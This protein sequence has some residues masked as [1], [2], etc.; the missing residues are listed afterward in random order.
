M[1][2]WVEPEGGRERG[3]LGLAKSFTQVLLNPVSFF[4][5]AVSPGDQAPGLVFAMVVVGVV[6]VTELAATPS[7]ALAFPTADWLAAVL[8]VALVVLLVTPAAVHALSAIQTLCLVI[9]TI[10]ESRG[11][12]SE[13]VQLIAYAAAPCVVTG[14]GVPVLTLLAGVWAW[15]LLVVGTSVVHEISLPRAVIAAAVPGVLAFGA[16]FGAIPAG[17]QVIHAAGLA[18]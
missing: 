12:V 8:T 3:P 13:T 7:D 1:T 18:F 2:T 14:L 5:E 11:G 15:C 4:D 9:A 17:E 16:G 6:A 10:S